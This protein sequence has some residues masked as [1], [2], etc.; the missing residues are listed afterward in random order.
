LAGIKDPG[1][2]VFKTNGAG[3]TG[4]YTYWYDKDTEEEVFFS[5]QMPH[6]W[7]EGTDIHPHVHWTPKTDGTT[8]ASRVCWGLEYTWSN[9][10][11]SFGNTS[12]SYANLPISY[13]GSP[14][15]DA[16]YLT[17]LPDISGAGKTFSSMLICRLFR[18]A[19]SSGS[20]DSYGYDAGLLEFDFHYEIDSFGSQD[21]FVK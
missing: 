19:T 1:F 21:E 8:S 6:N 9:I 16:H 11:G 17:E 4:V 5:C 2:A 15:A 3:S 10:T 7:K 12:I 14:I 20:S 18:D 13:T